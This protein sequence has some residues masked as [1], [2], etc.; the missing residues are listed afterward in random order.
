MHGLSPS[1]PTALSPPAPQCLPAFPSIRFAL[2]TLTIPTTAAHVLTRCPRAAGNFFGRRAV[3][4]DLLEVCLHACACTVTMCT[5]LCQITSSYLLMPHQCSINSPETYQPVS[6]LA[7]MFPQAPLP[8][9]TWSFLVGTQQ[10]R[11]GR[12][13]SSGVSYGWGRI[14]KDWDSSGSQGWLWSIRQGEGSGQAHM[15]LRLRVPFTEQI[16]QSRDGG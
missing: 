10:R 6:N 12:A 9:N 13:F 8:P 3:L 1:I 5:N 11:G 15:P 4:P 14:G 16:I 2:S 7:M